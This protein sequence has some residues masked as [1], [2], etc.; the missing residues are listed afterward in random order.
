M[1]IPPS[2]VT[3]NDSTIAILEYLDIATTRPDYDCDVSF[4]TTLHRYYTLTRYNTFG[5]F[6]DTMNAQ[7]SIIDFLV[8]RGHISRHEYGKRNAFRI[9]R[10]GQQHLAELRSERERDLTDSL[11]RGLIDQL[12]RIPTG[13]RHAQ[14]YHD[15]IYPLC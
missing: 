4:I 8:N 5:Y 7:D 11:L 1:S 13:R 2:N 14:A 9:Q 15:T 12:I 3:D 6:I 10:S